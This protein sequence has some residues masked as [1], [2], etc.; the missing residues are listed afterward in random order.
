MKT[1]FATAALLGCTSA[2]SLTAAADL[3][4]GGPVGLC[5]QF[6]W[7]CLAQTAEMPAGAVDDGL[8]T[9]H[10]AAEFLRNNA[11]DAEALEAGIVDF[12]GKLPHQDTLATVYAEVIELVKEHEGKVREWVGALAKAIEAGDNEAVHA[13][14]TAAKQAMK[15]LWE[16]GLSAESKAKLEGV[17]DEM[18]PLVEAWFQGFV[19]HATGGASALAER[20][21]S[22][23]EVV[24]FLAGLAK[25]FGVTEKDAVSFVSSHP[26]AAAALANPDKALAAIRGMSKESWMQGSLK[27]CQA[28]SFDV[29]CMKGAPYMEHAYDTL[30]A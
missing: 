6:G 10:E 21:V 16:H 13:H 19:K 27:W 26:Q 17:K 30:T 3:E 1:I 14:L 24:D 11:G 28:Q 23:K 15:E 5:R 18:L 12:F 7:F 20:A 22:K 8:A 25:E 4:S 9:G 29:D 2:V